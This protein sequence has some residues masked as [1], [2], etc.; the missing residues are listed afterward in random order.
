M[1]I[2]KN[3]QSFLNMKFAITAILAASVSAGATFGGL[4]FLKGPKEMAEAEAAIARFIAEQ[5]AHFKNRNRKAKIYFAA[6]DIEAERKR[7]SAK[8]ARRAKLA[9]SFAKLMKIM[10]H[11]A[12]KHHA[13]MKAKRESAFKRWIAARRA[14]RAAIRA[15]RHAA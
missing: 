2:I 15:R 12:V 1:G 3:I 14:H 10:H 6:K 9:G 8:F 4:D 11:K 7:A 13:A 5:V